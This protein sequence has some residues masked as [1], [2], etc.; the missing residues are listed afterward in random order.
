M[1]T[2]RDFIELSTLGLAGAALGNSLAVMAADA[3]VNRRIVL[4]EVQ[5]RHRGVPMRVHDAGSHLP[6][7]L[8][9]R[10]VHPHQLRPIP[11]NLLVGDGSHDRIVLERPQK[12]RIVVG[13]LQDGDAMGWV[14]E[15]AT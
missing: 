5:Q 1:T 7:A 6:I 4:Q 10:L 8:D 13:W 12:L 11:A 9:V 15:F 3:S 14:G 2:R